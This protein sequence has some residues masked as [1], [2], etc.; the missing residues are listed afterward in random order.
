M[1]FGMIE[2]AE[3]TENGPGSNF[4]FRYQSTFTSVSI[5][6][7]FPGRYS[8]GAIAM[9]SNNG[10]N[11][12]WQ[13]APPYGPTVTVGFNFFSPNIG[14]AGE[15]FAMYHANLAGFDGY[16][17]TLVINAAGKF[18]VY[19]GNVGTLLATGSIV[20]APSTWYQIEWE[21]TIGSG[22]AGASR[23]FV[24]GALDLNVSGVNTNGVGGT[25]VTASGDLRGLP[26]AGQTRFADLWMKDSAGSLGKRRVVTKTPT[27]NGALA[28][29]IPSAGSNFQC[30]D[31]QPPNSDTDF[32]AS[33]VVNNTDLYSFS[34]LPFNPRVIEAVQ[35]SAFAR[36]TDALVQQIAL[37][38][39]SGGTTSTGAAITLAATYAD[40]LRVLLTDPNTG[41]A[42]KGG[43]VDVAQFGQTIIA[44][45]AATDK[46]VS[47][48]MVEVLQSIDA[49]PPGSGGSGKFFRDL[50]DLGLDLGEIWQE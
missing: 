48:V 9:V 34:A 35:V 33:Q 36:A 4:T 50:W 14:T 23:I 32:V 28:Q 29:W 40:Y 44:Q 25:L 42:W 38:V 12:N 5:Q 18:E 41:I 26:G 10:M 30:V 39:K 16:L 3:W 2:G 24:E 46:R 21:V 11:F 6:P 47:Q 13:G 43:A 7:A 37:M 49:L 20:L 45:A 22:V 15:I 17:V 8:V 31:E 27:A 19:R 1:A